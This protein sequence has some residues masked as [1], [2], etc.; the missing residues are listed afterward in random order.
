MNDGL[1]EWC[2]HV[3][4]ETNNDAMHYWMNGAMT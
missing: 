2:F 4:D 3:M 1:R